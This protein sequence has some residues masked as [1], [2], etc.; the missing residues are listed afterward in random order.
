MQVKAVLFDLFDTLLLVEGGNAFYT[1]CLQKL[2]K[3]LTENGVDAPFEKFMKVY[4]EVRDALYAE[5]DK[6]LEEPHF[7]IR[8]WKTLQRLGY[9][10]ELSDDVV[11]KATECFAQ[12]FMKYVSLDENAVDVLQWLHGKYKLGIVSNFA[13][14]ECIWKLLEKYN[15]KKFFDVIIISAEVNKRK[16]SPE[17]FQKTLKSLN[18]ASHEAVFV[19]D[20]PSMDIEGAKNVGMKAILI[21]R[22]TSVTDTPKPTSATIKPDITVKSLKELPKIIGD[23]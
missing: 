9:N 6:N 14:P 23:C 12:E 5:A 7:N 17:I 18:V 16:P 21:I 19:G 22:R 1:P 13:I 10:Y 15:L 4:F 11:T 8:V 3:F 2:H 20:T